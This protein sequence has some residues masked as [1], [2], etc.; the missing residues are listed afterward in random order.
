MI[1]Y[2]GNPA[3]WDA[4]ENGTAV[5]IGVFDG[6]HLGHRRVLESMGDV[7]PK[8]DRASAEKH[9]GDFLAP[10]VGILGGGRSPN[11]IT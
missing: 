6:M 4:P 3:G 9:R 10:F 2:Q 1:I 11:F 5:A 8:D 7:A